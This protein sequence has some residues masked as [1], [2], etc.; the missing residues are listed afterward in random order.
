[1]I[2]R[3]RSILE[4]PWA[5]QMWNHFVGAD[6]S[7]QELVTRYICPRKNEKLLDIGCGP[8]NMVPYLP[9]VEYVGFDSNSEYIAQAKKSFPQLRLLCGRVED[10]SLP[11]FERF[12]IA[13]AIG[14]VHHLEDTEASQ[15]F[16][17]AHQALKE[18]GRLITL[19]GVWTEDQSPVAKFLLRRDRGRFVRNKE[20]YI[21]LASQYFLTVGA[22]VRHDMLRIPYSH[23]ILEC[24]R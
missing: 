12:D 24:R 11:A 8:G 5:Y 17:L 14:V 6:W 4:I 15:L 19:D 3:L 16:R 9:E 20:A 2:E 18:G 21:A 10:E 7:R 1:M 22:T 13:I 23:L